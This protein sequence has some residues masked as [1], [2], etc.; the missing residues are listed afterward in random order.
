M[1]NNIYADSLQNFC[2]SQ[3]STPTLSVYA[4]NAI[5]SH[6]NALKNNF[7]LTLHHLGEKFFGILAKVYSRIYPA[8]EWDINCYGKN[9]SYFISSQSRSSKSENF[10]WEFL[11]NIAAIEFAIIRCYYHENQIILGEYINKTAREATR[12][13]ANHHPYVSSPIDLNEHGDIFVNRSHEKQY[14]TI[15]ISSLLEDRP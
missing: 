13:L 7:P 10:D 1:K 15:E 4:N 8:D 9:F 12:L 3:L 11:S 5:A 2:L 14:F 6:S